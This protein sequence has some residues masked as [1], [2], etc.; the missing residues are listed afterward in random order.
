MIVRTRDEDV[1]VMCD[2]VLNDG[3]L[4]LNDVDVAPVDPRVFRLQGGGKEIVAGAAHILAARALGLKTMTILDVLAQLEVEVLLDNH[5]AAE[6][7]LVRALLNSLELG[8]EDCEGVIIR[9][10]NEEREVDQVV[11]VRKLG[12][13]LK[14]LG[15]VRG[16]L[17]QGRH[18]QDALLVGGSLGGRL[19]GI[20]VVVDDGGRVDDDGLM[21]VEDDG[22]VEVGVP[23]CLLVDG[24]VHWWLGG[25][26]AVETIRS[27]IPS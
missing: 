24:H 8:R 20:Q 10:A 26:P 4:A 18:N 25:A 22:G 1:L 13:Q 19:D 17:L 16:G 5:G 12:D 14:V 15:Q 2:K 3:A 23:R 27:A 7:S 21:T 9:V 6:G 11:G